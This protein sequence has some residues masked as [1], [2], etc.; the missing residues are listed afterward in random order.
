MSLKGQ[1]LST[2]STSDS[3]LALEQFLKS[4][5]AFSFTPAL[6]AKL[7]YA[8]HALENLAMSETT[9][10]KDDTIPSCINKWLLT[11]KFSISAANIQDPKDDINN[12]LNTKIFSNFETLYSGVLLAYGE[13]SL[14][15]VLPIAFDR[16]S[17]C[18]QIAVNALVFSPLPGKILRGIVNDVAVDHL[19][20]LVLGV[21]NASIPFKSISKEFLSAKQIG[22]G[23]QFEVESVKREAPILIYG[24]MNNNKCKTFSKGILGDVEEVPENPFASKKSKMTKFDSDSETEQKPKASDK[25]SELP[26]SDSDDFPESDDVDK[27]E[28]KH[29]KKLL[30]EDD[31]IRQTKKEI[32]NSL[33]DSSEEESSN[34]LLS[35]SDSDEEK[36]EDK[37]EIKE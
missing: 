22:T 21:F 20:V 12:V 32:E 11:G 9:K 23:V 6:S 27:L 35:D 34:S 13:Y 33:E 16:P 14:P 30:R 31:S 24:K 2:I 26:S 10:L 29:R 1:L 25:V 37:E 28:K 5:S 8:Q 36:K 3:S 15:A 18:C 7:K 17:M 19:S 4:S